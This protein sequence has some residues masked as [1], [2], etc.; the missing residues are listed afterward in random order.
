MYSVEDTEWHIKMRFG[1][2]ICISAGKAIIRVLDSTVNIAVLTAFWLLFSYGCYA[3]WDSGQVFKTAE[4][5]RYE[6]YKP[7]KEDGKSFEELKEI[8][9]EVISWLTVYGT[10]IDYP[11]TQAENNNKYV[12]TDVEGAYSLAGSIFL[13][14]RNEKDF[15][16]FT[17]ILYGHHMAKNAMF[18]DLEKFREK[19]FLMI[20]HMEICIMMGKIIKLNSGLF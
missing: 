12:N 18:G 9:P 13:D 1:K 6:V 20:I 17:S 14:C 8:N 4:A 16:D 11:C 15:S 19:E 7:T 10:N 5:G 3:L 2:S